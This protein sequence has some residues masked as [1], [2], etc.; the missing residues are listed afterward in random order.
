MSTKTETHRFT[1]ETF[2]I[3][4][5]GF[6]VLSR[7]KG[8]SDFQMGED[9]AQLSFDIYDGFDKLGL[10]SIHSSRGE[11]VKNDSIILDLTQM[12]ALRDALTTLIEQVS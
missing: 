11:E 8:E 6:H 1:H 3:A 7:R 10:L 5:D 2:P 9:A 12:T 4:A